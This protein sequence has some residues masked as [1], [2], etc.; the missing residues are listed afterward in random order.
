M[1]R[2]YDQAN[3]RLVYVDQEATAEFWD[4]HWSSYGHVSDT[5]HGISQGLRKLLKPY[6]ETN[7]VLKMSRKYLQDNATVLEGGCGLGQNVA[8]LTDMGYRAIGIEFAR[9]TVKSSLRLYPTLDIRVDDV[10]KT[11]FESASFDAYWSLGVIE[12]FFEGYLPIANEMARLVRPGGYLF[13]TFPHMSKLRK[14][15]A[16]RGYFPLLE[17]FDAPKGFYQFALNPSD[18]VGVFGERGFHLIEQRGI[19]GFKGFKDE[20]QIPKDVLQRIYD[21]RLLLASAFRYLI[22]PAL[23]S[24]AGHMLLLVMKRT[25]AQ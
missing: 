14:W 12:H 8:A 11:K 3:Q 2:L 23:N 13:L 4:E 20:I 19:S 7:L 22:E 1:K 9:R 21:S 6:F 5:T 18:V 10:R 15:K 16:K 17:S 24:W 25:G